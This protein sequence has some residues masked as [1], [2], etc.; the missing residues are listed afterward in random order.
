MKP[1]FHGIKVILI[2]HAIF[3]LAFDLLAPLMSIYFITKLEGVTLTEVG[4]GTMIYFLSWGLIEP[5]IGLLADKI[6]GFKDEVFFIVFGYIARGVVFMFFPLASS[7]WGLYMFQFALGS[8]R[9]I[10]EPSNRVL[11]AKFMG[12]KQ[13]AALWGLGDSTVTIAA[14]IGAGLGGYFVTSFGFAPVFK[15]VSVMYLVAGAV[16]LFM[17]KDVRKLKE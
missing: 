1:I 6:K 13:S 8:L 5:M 9:A 7:A 17:L 4:I 10:A 2:S 15:F 12:R 11:Y 14:A 16:N 3:W